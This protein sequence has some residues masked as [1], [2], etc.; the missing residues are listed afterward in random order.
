[1]DLDLGDAETMLART[2]DVLTAFL[3]GLP[4]EWLHRDDGPGTWSAYAI[5]GHLT[6]ADATNWLPRL[7]LIQEHGVSRVFEPFDRE[8]M[9]R[10]EPEPLGDLLARFR[11]GRGRTL[12]A[13]NLA[14]VDLRQTGTHPEF[15]E[16]TMG[17]VVAAWVA[18]DLTHLGQMA[19]VLAR[20]HR[21][22][23][24]P[25]RKYLPA[26]DRVAEAE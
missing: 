19:E 10:D 6:Y 24:G 22:D 13:L 11:S 21:T 26:L 5:L 17:N 15:G 4:D 14:T 3:T 1:M 8:A 7:R 12:T 9:L 23:V 18:H 25:Y 20:R 16:V 2:P